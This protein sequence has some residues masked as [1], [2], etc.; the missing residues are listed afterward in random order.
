MKP[1]KKQ[2][3]LVAV[4]TLILVALIYSVSYSVS[5]TDSDLTK[6][7]QRFTG[8][9]N[10]TVVQTEI[11]GNHLIALYTTDE[12]DY[13]AVASFQRGLN[14]NWKPYAYYGTTGICIYS[15]GSLYNDY[16]HYVIAGV[17]CDPRAVSYEAVYEYTD[18]ERDPAIIYSSEITESDFIHVYDIS[19]VFVSHFKIYDAEGNNIEPDLRE[20]FN[21]NHTESGGSGGGRGNYSSI[22]FT[23]L[24]VFGILAIGFL[25]TWYLWITPEKREEEE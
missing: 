1:A 15:F 23:N 24:I 7:I 12:L 20:E 3:I 18:V 13:K 16:E 8:S 19:Y 6:A 4:I 17:N 5:E 10:V 25:I 2:A 22:F 9:E 14:G 21:R 11:I